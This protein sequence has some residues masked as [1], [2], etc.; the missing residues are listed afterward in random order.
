MDEIVRVMLG[1]IVSH[2]RVRR[3]EKNVKTVFLLFLFF[4]CGFSRFLLPFAS[5]SARLLTDW[6]DDPRRIGINL[7]GS[8][9]DSV[10]DYELISHTDSAR[11]LVLDRTHR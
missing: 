7:L 11:A 3:W 4:V 10:I 2:G 1:S 9:E 6:S 5:F 8:R